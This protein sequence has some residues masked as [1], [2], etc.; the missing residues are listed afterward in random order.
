MWR[1]LWGVEDD[2]HDGPCWAAECLQGCDEFD[3]PEEQ[4][5]WTDT[6]RVVPL[7][8]FC[9]LFGS[10]AGIAAVPVTAWVWSFLHY[11]VPTFGGR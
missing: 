4:G 7:F 1:W 6:D 9:L 2:E 11:A 3:E 8:L 10:V 5:H